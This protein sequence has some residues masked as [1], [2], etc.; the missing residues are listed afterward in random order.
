MSDSVEHVSLDKVSVPV[1][2]VVFGITSL[3]MYAA[4]S[5]SDTQDEHAKQ[6]NDLK[7]KSAKFE[8]E[9]KANMSSFSEALKDLI[10]LEKQAAKDRQDIKNRVQMLEYKTDDE[11][12]D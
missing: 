8:S 12:T 4:A 9:Y 1:L 11:A 2:L 3:L 7:L 6:I 10:D 5:F